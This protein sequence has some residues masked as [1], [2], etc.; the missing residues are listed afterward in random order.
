VN[1]VISQALEVKLLLTKSMTLKLEL[2]CKKKA[3]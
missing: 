1:S 3:V 2:V